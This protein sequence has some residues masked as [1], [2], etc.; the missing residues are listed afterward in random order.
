MPNIPAMSE[1]ILCH[2]ELQCYSSALLP[3]SE[4]P[5]LFLKQEDLSWAFAGNNW[6]LRK[7]ASIDPHT[8]ARPGY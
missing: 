7:F 8:K 1:Y 3:S 5:L 6:T 4:A 2:W